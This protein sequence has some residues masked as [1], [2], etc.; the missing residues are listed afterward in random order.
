MFFKLLLINNI[1][2]NKTWYKRGKKLHAFTF[3]IK[4]RKLTKKEVKKRIANRSYCNDNKF[5]K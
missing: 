2:R 5:S 4:K 1:N 3:I